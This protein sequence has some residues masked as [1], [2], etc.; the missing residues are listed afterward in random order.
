MRTK[1]LTGIVIRKRDFMEKDLIVTVLNE[2]GLRQ[3]LIVKGAGN[4]KSKRKSHLEPMNLIE[5]NVYAANTQSYLQTVQSR[6]SFTE[7]KNHLDRILRMQVIF[8]II[9]K[10]IFPSD[11]HPEIYEL[12]LDTLHT[13]NKK[14]TQPFGPEISL[15]KLAH[16]LGFLP[17]FKECGSCH[18]PLHENDAQW[19]HEVGTLA[20]RA[21]SP[22]QH[23]HLPLKY[24]KAMEF[25]R[26]ATKEDLN[27]V[28]L[29]E[30]EKKDLR[31]L[32]MRFFTL[33][34]DKPLK[35]LMLL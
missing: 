22:E 2:K 34:I 24:R 19:N 21:C 30:Q 18:R 33:N 28:I 23:S 15:I 11:A 5:G 29:Q 32:T 1:N 13:M 17:S 4:G 16:F 9:D 35:S 10:T 12:L 20:C 6:C 7:M 25:F 8:E 14:Y 3:D 31:D 27:K 26:R